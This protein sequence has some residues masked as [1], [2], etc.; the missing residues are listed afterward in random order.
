MLTWI[1]EPKVWA[2]MAEEWNALL[3]RSLLPLPFLRHEYLWRWWETLGAGEWPEGQLAVAVYRDEAGRLQGAAPFFI[4]P[5]RYGPTM[6]VIGSHRLTDFLDVLVTREAEKAFFRALGDALF[7]PS[8]VFPQVRRWE[9]WN[10]L[11]ESPLRRGAADWTARYGLKSTESP[12]E[13]APYLALPPSWEAYLH[14]V[15]KKQRH[16]IRRKLRRAHR[17]PHAVHW[18]RVTDPEHLDAELD[19]LFA[20]MQAHPQ[21][22]AFFT[23]ARQAWL[24]AVCHDA[25]HHGWLFFAFLTVG[26]E[27]AASFLCFDFHRRLWIYNSGLNPKYK[28]LSPGWV[29]L[30]HML[31][32]AI[33]R[34]YEGVDFMRGPEGYKYRFGARDRELFWML[35]ER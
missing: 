26:G 14:Q 31:Q 20:L 6:M 16:E 17:H 27:R 35:L 34:G 32:W 24:R 9:W 28:Q 2:G 25:L 11:P 3:D 7:G 15:G 13:V 21:K 4:T 29:L 33:A 30:A 10:L 1:T 23:P 19:A 12:C 8:P 22:A 18:Y 5:T